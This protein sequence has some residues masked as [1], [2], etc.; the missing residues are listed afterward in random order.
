MD[1][2]RLHHA[3]WAGDA[4]L[5]AELIAQGADVNQTAPTNWRQRPLHRTLEFRITEPKHAGHRE[6]VRLLLAAGAEPHVRATALDWTPWE[7]AVF[8]GEVEAEKLLRKAQLRAEPHPDGMSE[9]WL[10]AAAR[11]PEEWV[12]RRLRPLEWHGALWKAATPLQMAVGH[13]GHWKVARR[14]VKRGADVNAG[15]SLLHAACEWHL[16][17]LVAGLEFLHGLG[18]HVENCDEK[19][20]TALH[21]AAFLGYAKAVR[22][23]L[24]LGADKHRKSKLGLTALD[25]A[26]AW[27]KE[28]V[29]E[30]LEG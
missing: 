6:V 5:V 23:L 12:W 15:V 2:R 26:Q 4:P 11:M 3:C 20:Q 7:L 22:K 14:M 1:W 21:K 17:H 28:A 10:L 18:W 19:G 9:E 16:E 8:A 24:E 30:A 25:T 29:V 27:R 13:A